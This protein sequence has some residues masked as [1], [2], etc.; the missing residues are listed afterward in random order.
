MV[1]ES[2]RLF[3]GE[4]ERN[5]LDERQNYTFIQ[6]KN[7]LFLRRFP[8]LYSLQF[9]LEIGSPLAARRS[10]KLLELQGFVSDQSGEEV[11]GKSNIFQDEVSHVQGV[12]FTSLQKYVPMYV[13][14]IYVDLIFF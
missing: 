13:D 2:C 3:H 6:M 12:T 7:D 5:W 10:E 14:L 11:L 4:T 9:R 1:S 8:Q